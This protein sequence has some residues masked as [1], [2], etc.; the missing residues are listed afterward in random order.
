MSIEFT[1]QSLAL[2]GP[3]APVV[4]VEL[5]HDLPV[6]GSDFFIVQF[7]RG[8]TAPDSVIV[9]RDALRFPLAMIDQSA[10]Y[11]LLAFKISDGIADGVWWVDDYVYDSEQVNISFK[12]SG[13][14]AGSGDPGSFTGS[15]RVA[16]QPAA[17]NVIATALDA[18]PPYQLARAVSDAGNGQYTLEWQGYT[19]QMLITVFDDY[20]VPH[21]DG[22]ARGAGERVHPTQY[23]G[24]TY[25]VVQS[26]TLG[27]EPVWPTTADET[28]WSG[29]VQLIA[30]PF[31]RPVS[32]GPFIV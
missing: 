8:L 25:R 30:V 23:N 14:A 22:E 19:G 7:V 15:V 24:Y 29:T 5:Q 13:D 18:D 27:V 26:G 28:V 1:T 16:D 10:A 17:R 12:S 3:G 4:L 31:Y 21:V 20:G 9:V 2:D 32:E 6:V 11:K